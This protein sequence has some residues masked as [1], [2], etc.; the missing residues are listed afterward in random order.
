M[1]RIASPKNSTE[2]PADY[3][4]VL[5]GAFSSNDLLAITKRPQFAP[6]KITLTNTT[7]AGVTVTFLQEDGTSTVVTAPPNGTPLDILVPVKT[8]VSGGASV[9][10]HIYWWAGHTIDINK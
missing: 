7:A 9:E 4:T 3:L 6:Q 2:R 1:P 5:T 8:L 10:A